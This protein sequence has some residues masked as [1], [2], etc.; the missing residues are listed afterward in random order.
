MA[1]TTVDINKLLIL[2]PSEYA[3]KAGRDIVLSL[4]GAGLSKEAVKAILVYAFTELGVVVTV[5][6]E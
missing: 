2:V 5:E 6:K 3:E 4:L 1:T